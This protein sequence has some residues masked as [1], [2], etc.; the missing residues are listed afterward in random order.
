MAQNVLMSSVMRRFKVDGRKRESGFTV[1]EIVIVFGVISIVLAIVTLGIRRIVGS[2]AL[3]RA[4]TITSVELRRAQAAAIAGGSGSA[5]TVEFLGTGGL[6]VY[7]QSS[8]TPVKTVAPPDEWPPTVTIN[9]AATTFQWCVSPASTSNKCVTFQP[10]GYASQAGAVAM[11]GGVG[12]SV[13][14]YVNVAGATGR[15]SVTQQ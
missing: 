8:S 9:L 1:I 3:R 14:Y 12:S 15:V 13:T 6:R 10:L 4:A 7:V 11:T 2:F 5:Y